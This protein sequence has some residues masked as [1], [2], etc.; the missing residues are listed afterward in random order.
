MDGL[1]SDYVYAAIPDSSGYLYIASQKGISIYDGYRFVNHPFLQLGVSDLYLDHHTFYFYNDSGLNRL[2]NFHTVPQL[3]AANIFT[4]TD[5]NNDAYSNIFVDNKQRIWSTD[6]NYVKY[7]LPG[8]GRISSFLIMPENKDAGINTAI[9]EVADGEIWVAARSGLWVWHEADNKLQ[10]HP[11]TAINRLSYESAIQLNDKEVLLAT[12]NGKILRVNP[13]TG[14]SADLPSLPDHDIVRG[15]LETAKGLFLYTSRKIYQKQP[16]AY[17]EICSADDALINHLSSDARTHLLWVS[18]TKGIIKL[19]PGPEAVETRMFPGTKTQNDPVISIAAPKAGELWMLT[20]SGEVWFYGN[21]SLEKR[22]SGEMD[23][24]Y[25]ALDDVEHQVILSTQKGIFRW[26]DNRFRQL[27]LPG[28]QIKS[29]IRKVLV[30]PQNEFWVVFSGQPIARYS[31]PGF[32][33]F[34]RAFNN[35]SA[36]WTGN[37]WNDILTDSSGITWLAGWMPKAWGIAR[38]DAAK[39]TFIEISDSTINKKTL[40]VF[41]GDYYNSIGVASNGQLLFSAYGGWNRTDEKGKIIQ[42]VDTHDYEIADTYNVGISEDRHGNVF[43]GTREGLHVWL[44]EK[45]KVVRLSQIDGLPTDYLVNAHKKLLNGNLALGIPNGILLI[46][47]EKILQT[48]LTNRLSL[49]QISVNGV[50]RNDTATSIELSR[51]ETALYLYFS[52]L[53]YLDPHKVYFRY[54]YSDENNWH[55]LGHRPELSLHHIT[56]GEYHITVEVFDNLANRQEQTLSLFVKAHPAWWQT[57]WFRITALILFTGLVA[58]LIKRRINNIWREAELKHR[59]AE[60]EM[61]ALRAQMNPHFIFNCINGIDALIQSNDKYYATVYLNKFARLLRNVLDSSKQNT[62]SLAKDLETLQLYID[63]EQLR[64]ENKFTAA[65]KADESLLLDDYQVP[66]LVVQPYIENAILHGLRHR[67]DN[68]GRLTITVTKNEEHIKYIIEDNGVGRDTL[69]NGRKHDHSYGMQM[70][71]DRVKFFNN[72]EYASVV[73]TDL[74][75]EGKPA[76]TRVQ[77]LLKIQ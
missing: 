8:N 57:W 1:P 55:D 66:P 25:Y 70:S 24:R 26:Q 14:Q 69:K 28:L 42:K 32:E 73:I 74:K 11:A 47:P 7:Y 34:S 35:D 23:N 4:D 45:N 43:F 62:V 39:N 77:V 65:I 17:Q 53:S 2:K 30:T 58:I 75:N 48:R 29:D 16:A 10:L 22:F 54:K 36:F 38:Y 50:F 6:F 40:G 9:L 60:T 41:V 19:T 49:T 52:D 64:D 13:A 44:K 3:L 37:T 31:Y 12:T 33:K 15:F 59:I 67:P 63:L 46:D 21:G 61:M 72:E 27:H 68:G 20:R 51:K 71:G 56:P 76:G 5:P 18:T